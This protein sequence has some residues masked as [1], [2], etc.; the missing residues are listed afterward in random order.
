MRKLSL[1]KP[2]IYELRQQMEFNIHEK[3]HES[4]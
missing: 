1:P 3:E 4:V 2:Q